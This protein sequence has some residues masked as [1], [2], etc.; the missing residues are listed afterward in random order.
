MRGGRLTSCK[1]AKDRTSMAIS[2]EQAR[3]LLDQH[4]VAEAA[5][6]SMLRSMR[7]QGVRR[8]NVEKNIGKRKYAFNALQPVYANRQ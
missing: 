6:E 5:L 4:G 8:M 3:L 2:L 1:S 7:S